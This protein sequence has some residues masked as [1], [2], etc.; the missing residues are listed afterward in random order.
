MLVVSLSGLCNHLL[1]ADRV[2]AALVLYLKVGLVER[3]PLSFC[4]SFE[5][6]GLY[7]FLID[8]N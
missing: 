1:V 5:E 4:K 6:V 2:L 3:I 7:E 8:L